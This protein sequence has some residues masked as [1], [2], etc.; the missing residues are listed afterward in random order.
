MAPDISKRGGLR[1]RSFSIAGHR[2]SVALEPEFW[3]ALEEEASEQGV[4]LAALVGRVDSLRGGRNLASA[5][6][7][8]ALKRGGG[9][10]LPPV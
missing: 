2:T 5:L 10:P 3:A 4:A 1:K 6:R 8:C 9:K 7:V